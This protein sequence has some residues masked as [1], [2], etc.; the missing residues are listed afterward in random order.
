MFIPALAAIFTRR[1]FYKKKFQD[2]NLRIG[3]LKDYFKFW[4]ITLGITGASFLLF[5]LLGAVSWDFSGNS[6]LTLLS[7]QLS[8]SGQNINNLPQGLTPYTMLLLYFIGGLT[9]FNI[10][11]G[12]LSGFGEEFGWRGFMLPEL[13]KIKPWIAFIVGGLIWFLWHLPL[14]L[15]YPSSASKIEVAHVFI[16]AIASILSF[17][18]FSYVYVKTRSIWTASFVHAVF[19][20][21]NQSLGY[22][23]VIVNQALADFGLMVVMLLAAAV[24]YFSGELK[25]FK[26]YLYR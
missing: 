2:A 9:L 17:V 12:M 3:K 4:L 13:Y 14:A 6:F 8:A 19:N 18:F 10:I 5:T 26:R 25:V 15:I 20:N 16:V 21:S 23:S 1:F 11:P 24:L 7:E 22:F